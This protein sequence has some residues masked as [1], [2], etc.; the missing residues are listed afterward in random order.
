MNLQ[1]RIQITKSI[2]KQPTLMSH[3]S[4]FSLPTSLSHIA[5]LPL[6]V[7]VIISSSFSFCAWDVVPNHSI[8]LRR[9]DSTCAEQQGKHGPFLHETAQC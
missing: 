2:Q 9:D 7:S 8:D 6:L 3:P 4:H 1:S 5:M